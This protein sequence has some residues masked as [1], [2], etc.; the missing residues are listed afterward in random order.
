MTT[1]TVT[2]VTEP[3]RER[4]ERHWLGLTQV[5]TLLIVSLMTTDPS[6][7]PFKETIFYIR[8]KTDG[9]QGGKKSH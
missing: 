1:M 4:K 3:P 6:T 7:L 8:I 9:N 2:T 5:S